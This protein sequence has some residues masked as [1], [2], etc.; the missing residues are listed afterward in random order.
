MSH[1]YFPKRN[2]RLYLT[3]KNT[4]NRQNC[5]YT[6]LPPSVHLNATWGVLTCWGAPKF[7]Y[8]SRIDYTYAFT[9]IAESIE[10]IQHCRCMVSLLLSSVKLHPNNR[11]CCGSRL[12]GSV[13]INSSAFRNM[14]RCCSSDKPFSFLWCTCKFLNSH[15]LYVACINKLMLKY[16]RTV[17][18]KVPAKPK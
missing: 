11:R 15:C 3:Q 18:G 13:R 14:R 7:S 6:K 4:Y 9:S 16:V 5:R 8:T 2:S 12:A 10:A 17:G 1:V